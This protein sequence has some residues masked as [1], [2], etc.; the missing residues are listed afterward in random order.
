MLKNPSKKFW[1]NKIVLITGHT[2]FTGSWLSLVLNFYGAK[3][4]GLSLKPNTQPSMFN[5]LKIK[6]KIIKSYY[7][8]INDLKKTKKILYKVKPEII[9]HLAAQPLVNKSLLEP[10]KT[11]NTNIIG[12]LNICEISKKLK[13]LKHLL[14]VT[15]D[16]CYKNLNSK[17]I[18]FFKEEDELGGVEPYSASKACAEILIHSYRGTYFDKNVSITTARA[19]NII[20]G[21]DWAEDRLIPDIFKSLNSKKILKIRYPNATRPWQHVLDVLNGYILLAETK[22]SG[23][24]NFGPT[25]KKTFKVK[26]ILSF[27]KK[28]NPK[29]LWKKE[30]PKTKNES[31]N[32]NLNVNKTV[33][34][35]KWRSRWNLEKSLLE[36][37]KW[38]VSFYRGDN[39]N[40][41]TYNQIKN[42]FNL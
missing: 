29:F 22:Y 33:K 42:F 27:F 1:K 17:K 37:N 38:Y 26:K 3:I 13:K 2:G 11:F 32:L 30:I 8:D 4:Y 24:W 14:I 16:K 28:K 9:F 21:G 20:G 6:D 40:L 39:I 18:K 10:I 19:G 12:T 36:T 25:I 31:I 35:L 41:I 23:A 15:T 7:C 5:I 34:K